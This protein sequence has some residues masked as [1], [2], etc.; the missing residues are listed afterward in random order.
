VQVSAPYLDEV[1]LTA[2][3]LVSQETGMGRANRTAIE[4]D[5]AWGLRPETEQ[6]AKRCALGTRS[7]RSRGGAYAPT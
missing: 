6:T 7:V 1:G 5:Q 4:N 2:E 3:A